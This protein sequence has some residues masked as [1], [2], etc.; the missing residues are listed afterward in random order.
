MW[1]NVLAGAFR[2]LARNRIYSAISVGGLALGLAAVILAALYISDELNFDRFVPGHQDVYVVTSKLRMPNQSDIAM[3]YAPSQVADWLKQRFPRVAVARLAYDQVTVGRGALQAREDV[4]WVDPAFFAIMPLPALAGKLR[5]SMQAPD[6]VVITRSLARKYFGRDAPVGG[7]LTFDR[8]HPLRV[9][10]V[11]DDL[12]IETHLT[13]RIFASGNS[14][15]SPLSRMA[16][17]QPRRGF[18]SI[19]NTALPDQEPSY[20]TE[21]VRLRLYLRAPDSRTASVVA[22][23]LAAFG[24][25]NISQMHDLPRGSA[26]AFSLVPV[27]ALHLQAFQGVNLGVN[28]LRSSPAS[29]QALAVIA[30]LILAL[31]VINFVN[32][33]TALAAQ[34]AV[35]IGVRK[36]SG[37]QRSQLI[38]QFIGEALIY[39]T[40]AMVIAVALVELSLPA[41]NA[42]LLRGMS[43]PYWR[44]PEVLVTLLAGTLVLAVLAGAYPAFVLAS[45]RP[46]VVLK[47]GPIEAAGPGAVRRALVIFQFAVLV[48]MLIAVAVIWRQTRFAMNEGLRL[49][50]DQVL[51]VYATPCRGAFEDEVR[52]LPGV[53]A[54]A[55]SSQ[56]MLGLDG[57]DPTKFVMNASRPGGSPIQTDLGLADFGM[58]ELYGIHP[59]AGRTFSSSRPGDSLPPQHFPD[60]QHGPIVINQAAARRLGF[61]NA[62]D[63]MNRTISVGPGY[64]DFIVVGVVPDF[65]LDLLNATV[66][67]TVFMVDFLNYP[68]GQVLNVKLV[69]RDVPQTLAAIDQAWRRTGQPGAI[70]RQFLDAY[71]QQVY[72]GAIRQGY[73]ATALAGVALCLACFGLL[74]LAAITTARRTKE[75]G[76]R[77]AMG[78]STLDVVRLLLWQFTQP[79]LWANLIAWPAAWWAMD[80]WLHGFAYRVDLPP[81]LFLA[82]T[83]AAVIIAWATVSTHAF[84]VARARPVL[85][86][87]YE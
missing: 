65:T 86:L 82:A 56:S 75:I 32:L 54:A 31:A 68:A 49:D 7:V 19:L 15:F 78:A 8:D 73:L 61:R 53:R 50:K 77:K 52:R 14:A 57:F 28:E 40:T 23:D 38:G 66:K 84:L 76:V 21:Y 29:L 47:G 34:R 4:A 72:L 16:R 44:Q 79:V 1:R 46:A 36:A 59:V 35:E 10:A 42:L 25:R 26:L 3:D 74:G 37:A 69:G 70:R 30:A 83:A 6:A 22:A 24:P 87:R 62:A 13:Q 41:M 71:L 45:F 58:F 2:N 5:D 48:G 43:F 81:W 85:A 55:C 12:P 9:A 17:Q 63:A 39:V 51:V 18:T 67:P 33:T 20:R 80:R 60:L 11:V 27:T 64:G